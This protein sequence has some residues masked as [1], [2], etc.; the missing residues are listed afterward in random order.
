[1]S[2]SIQHFAEVSTVVFD[3]LITEFYKDPTDFASFVYG[4]TEELRVL[5]L[6]LVRE[7]IE[8]MDQMLCKSAK[9]KDRF[10]VEKH[11]KKQLLLSLGT[12]NLSK[13]L[14]TDKDTSEMEY[15]IDRILDLN[16]HERIT[17]DAKARALKESVQSSYRRGGEMASMGDD[18]SK[19]AIKDMIHALRFPEKSWKPLTKKRVV[20]YLYIEADEDHV[21]LQF[22]NQKG[23]LKR[24]KKGKK[25]NCVITKLI[26]VHEGIM[27][28]SPKSKRHRLINPHYFSRTAD[29]CSNEELW[30]NVYQYIED[31]YDLS[32]IKRIYLSSDGGGWIIAGKRRIAGIIHLL[33]QFHLEKS[34]TKLTGHMKDSAEDAKAELHKEIIKGTKEGFMALTSRLEE[35]LPKDRNIEK[36]RESRDY[37]INNWTA[38]RYRLKKVEGKVGSSTEGHVSHVLS[39]RMST[40]AL[41]WSKTGA[42]KMAQLRAYYMNGGDMLKLVRYQKEVLPKAAGVE[43]ADIIRSYITVK[44]SNLHGEVGKYYDLMQHTM[45][46]NA[47]KQAFF[48]GHIWGL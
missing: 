12:I 7:T 20:D 28:E 39:S 18:I 36:Y 26:Y 47:K 34:L 23:D 15:L 29:G 43:D 27:G 38:A 37:I 2:E 11:V 41:G 44:E 16:K 22:L 19:S 17:E 30:D 45:S 24:D 9:R 14:F 4:I 1:M 48:Q 35:Y 21:S 33:D 10:Y 3:K 8:G 5:G 31:T 46:I 13:T 42:D 40:H 32:H 25:N 6:N